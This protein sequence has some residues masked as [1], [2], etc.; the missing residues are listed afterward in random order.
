MKTIIRA[1]YVAA[2]LT[3]AACGGGAPTALPSELDE[4]ISAAGEAD[5]EV[6]LEV[7]KSHQPAT[8]TTQFNPEIGGQ[9]VY[10][11]AGTTPGG[12]PFK[13]VLLGD[14]GID[15]AE[16][17]ANARIQARLRRIQG[18]T[19]LAGRMI[20][21]GPLAGQ[22]PIAF[23]AAGQNVRFSG[24]EAGSVYQLQGVADFKGVCAEN[25]LSGSYS[26]KQ[27]NAELAGAL[28]GLRERGKAT[29]CAAGAV[30]SQLPVALSYTAVETHMG[31]IF[32][33]QGSLVVGATQSGLGAQAAAPMPS[34]GLAI[35]TATL[36][37]TT[38]RATST[39][40][41]NV[42][43]LGGSSGAELV[44]FSASTGTLIFN[45]L[46]GNLSSLAV[47][48]IIT[49]APR[50][51]APNGFLRKVTRIQN[52][53]DGKVE[54]RTA[55]ALATDL[56]DEADISVDQPFDSADVQRASVL[57]QGQVVYAA[58]Q[59]GPSAQAMIRQNFNLVLYDQDDNRSTT[60][61]QI[62][63]S[64]NF[65]VNPRVVIDFKCRR[66]F[67][68]DPYFLG[69]FILDEEAEINVSAKLKKELRESKQI[70][71]IA[72]P[73]IVAG[74]LVFVPDIV[75]T[76]D[77]EGVVR[78]EV[79]V[80]AKQSL[81][82]EAGV[83]YDGGFTKINE[84]TTNVDIIG[85]TLQGSV[86]V[87]AGVYAAL[88][89][90]LYGVAGV[91]AE[92]GPYAKFVAQYPAQPYWTMQYG[93]EGNLGVDVDLILFRKEWDVKLF[94]RVF[95]DK[96]KTAPN[97]RPQ[98]LEIGPKYLCDNGYAARGAIP[99]GGGL[100]N[101][102]LIALTDDKEDGAGTGT[103]D[104]SSSRD[105][106][107]GRTRKADKHTLNYPLSNGTHT[108]TAVLT[109]S[110]GATRTREFQVLLS[111]SQCQF[112]GGF[113]NVDITS[114]DNPNNLP[115]APIVAIGLDRSLT[116][117]ARA[118][119]GA[120]ALCSPQITWK[121]N[122]ENRNAG[123]STG[124]MQQVGTPPLI[125]QVCTHTFTNV[126]KNLSPQ[127]I[128]AKLTHNGMTVTD[129]ID[130]SALIPVMPNLGGITFSAPS[131]TRYIY[132]GD[133][134]SFS[135]TGTN[136]VWSSSVAA[137]NINGRTGNSVNARFNS[138][139]PRTIVARIENGQGGFVSKS[140]TVNVLSA[141]AKP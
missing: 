7:L 103:I 18:Q 31:I 108:I 77:V 65:Q 85:P 125:Q 113:P 81:R 74:P 139:G 86:E 131:A 106:S 5:V 127:T 23:V 140:V 134:V 133:Q 36:P 55:K 75:V 54:V 101:I 10:E 73:A 115:F 53:N 11:V 13:A 118:N 102:T 128:T 87:K 34:Q 9:T 141:L 93:I 40:K 98:F 138:I 25:G 84:V 59:N 43:Q 68:S 110:Q 61:D 57:E 72:L 122:L 56:L 104:W 132:E 91:S 21:T 12:K 69:K 96:T 19:V 48:D 120:L 33:L 20:P 117:T 6:R 124:V 60:D 114:D 121:S 26:F 123:T 50:T 135:A 79:E 67:C 78:V 109:D 92:A 105:G 88:R 130:V 52:T 94:D 111:N 51:N 90:M 95:N 112:P 71:R 16:F 62:V 35:P 76:V 63:V 99:I 107:L 2:I 14:E 32:A 100:S 27:G 46:T 89:L 41:T 49:S 15:L 17:R 28:T 126:Y 70:V 47:N 80:G 58:A 97:E 42:K 137:D 24:P 82:I 116:L 129:S 8:I 119:M 37:P 29:A 44:S 38:L 136:P 39:L 83:K 64:G 3:L 66:S 30:D 1:G 22:N 4:L 45:R